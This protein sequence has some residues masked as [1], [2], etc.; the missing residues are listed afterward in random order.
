MDTTHSYGFGATTDLSLEAAE[1]KLRAALAE[2]GFGILTEID[3][4]ETLQQKIGVERPP[5][6]ILGACNPT[7]ANQALENEESIGLLLPCNIVV[8]EKSG[9]TVIEILDPNLMAEVTGNSGLESIAAEAR[10][11]LTNALESVTAA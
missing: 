8:Y 4:A 6:R 1:E 9:S 10:T 11:R 3:V 2:Q 5:Y 7:L